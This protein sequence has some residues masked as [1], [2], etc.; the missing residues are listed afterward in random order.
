MTR[1]RRIRIPVVAGT[2][3]RRLVVNIRIEPSVAEKV[4]P[5]PFSPQ[6]VGGYGIGGID[7]VRLA[8]LRPAFLPSAAGGFTSEIAAHRIAVQWTEG[9][10]IC[11]GAYM[12]R[13]D[14]SSRL[15][16]AIGG[17]FFPG[18]HRLAS[19]RVD[20]GG[21]RFDVSV[22]SRDRGTRVHVI[23]H[24]TGDMPDNSVFGTIRSVTEFFE[25]ETL[26]YA[27]SW[28]RSG[29]FEGLELRVE[30]WEISPLEIELL[31]SSYFEDLDLF[32]AGSTELDSAVL[33]RG[34]P[35]EW[36]RPDPIV[37]PSV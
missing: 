20:E 24:T 17:R 14:T 28:G 26:G 34:I 32:P 10:S 7:L 36:H 31:S 15:T 8:R 35:H 19:F 16:A 11:T 9:G 1:S 37:A 29:V 4:L 30:G 12:P 18:V 22:E 27:P 25:A 13:R 6:L 2:I 33:M 23:A 21:G 3:E 5:E